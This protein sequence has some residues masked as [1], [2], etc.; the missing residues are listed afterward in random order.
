[1]SKLIRC[2]N[3]EEKEMLVAFIRSEKYP[4]DLTKDQ[5]RAYR[6]KAEHFVMRGNDICYRNNGTVLKAIFEYE[7]D[8]IDHIIKTEHSLGHVGITKMVNL[9]NQKYYGIPKSA[10]ADYS[11]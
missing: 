11:L 9:L 1:M 5:K 7:M 6:R 4:D 2:I 8:L 3:R 10:I